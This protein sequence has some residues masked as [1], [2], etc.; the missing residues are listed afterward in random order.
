MTRIN[1]GVHPSELPDKLLLAEHRE[2]TRIPNAITSKKAK[3]VDIPAHFTLGKGHVKY[4]Y[5]KMNT[6]HTRYTGIYDE[7]VKRG[8]KVT[9][10]K[11]SFNGIPGELWNYVPGKEIARARQ[12]IIERIKSKGFELKPKPNFFFSR[13]GNTVYEQRIH[14]ISNELDRVEVFRQLWMIN[15][16]NPNVF[17]VRNP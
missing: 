3:I 4:F 15:L 11:S 13:V 2:I 6:L 7:C 17:D 16:K 1:L 5:D 10:K 9:D 12:I 14:E 8:F